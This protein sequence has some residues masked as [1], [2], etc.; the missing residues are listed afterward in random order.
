MLIQPFLSAA[1]QPTAGE[2]ITVESHHSG[3]WQVRGPFQKLRNSSQCIQPHPKRCGPPFCT[4]E[5][6]RQ[7]QMRA[8]LVF[9]KDC[10]NSL[11]LK[12]EM[13]QVAFGKGERCF[14]WALREEEDLA[15]VGKRG[16]C[17]FKNK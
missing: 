11:R 7:K 4:E 16:S 8:R 15:P 10:Q 9:A 1:L 13:P 5:A 3:I 17:S 14:V 6:E 12:C 2:M